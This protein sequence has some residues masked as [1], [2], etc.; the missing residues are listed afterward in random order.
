MRQILVGSTHCSESCAQLLCT[1]VPIR[2]RRKIL[3]HDSNLVHEVMSATD[4]ARISVTQPLLPALAQHGFALVGV[5]NVAPHSARRRNYLTYRAA[6]ESNMAAL[7]SAKYGHGGEGNE[8]KKFLPLA[9]K[10]GLGDAGNPYA[11]PGSLA[12]CCTDSSCEVC[13]LLNCGFSLNTSSK[14]SHYVTSSVSGAIQWSTPSHLGLMAIAVCRA[15]VGIPLV[16]G[17][18][19]DVAAIPGFHSCIASD[20]NT[21]NDG[22]YLFRDDAIEALHIVLFR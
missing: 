16:V 14:L 7:K 9:L 6:V 19:A 18:S 15:V 17:S 4:R 8:Q 21:L 11:L 12:S 1:N 2:P 3:L 20:G 5:L 10:C 13:Q 22:S